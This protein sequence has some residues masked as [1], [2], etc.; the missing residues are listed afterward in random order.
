M[1]QLRE[2]S[3]KVAD[4]GVVRDLGYRQRQRYG[5][6]CLVPRLLDDTDACECI[7]DKYLIDKIQYF[8]IFLRT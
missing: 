7:H 1:Q 5:H 3:S 2:G 4:H 8:L 6:L